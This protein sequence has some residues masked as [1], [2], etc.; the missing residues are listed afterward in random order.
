MPRLEAI[1][2]DTAPEKT[3]ALLD[4]MATG[5]DLSPEMTRMMANSPAVLQGYLALR[6]ALY[7][8]VLSSRLGTQLALMIAET[9]RSPYCMAMHAITGWL[10]GVSDA[11]LEAA[12]VARSSDPK[13]E[14]A[15]DFARKVVDY[16]GE[17]SDA[18]FNRVRQAGYTDEEIAEIIGNVALNIFTSYFN[19]VAQTD[20]DLPR[21]DSGGL[22]VA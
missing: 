8:G 21:A 5:W 3:K 7:T 2:P 4:Q 19:L 14:A 13:V 22:N 6:D 15:L 16:R 18:E 11:E 12:R 1:T 10:L 9:N 20:I 17:I